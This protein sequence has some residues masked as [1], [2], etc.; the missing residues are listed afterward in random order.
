MEFRILGPLE[1]AQDGHLFT[2]RGR[3][4]QALL[5]LLLLNAGE[6]VSRERLIDE[7]W[8]DD[9]PPTAAKTLQVHV[10]RL[11][12]E[13]GDVVVTSGG[14]YLIEVEPGG[15]DLERFRQLVEE[16]REALAAGAPER[17]RERLRAALALW[18]GPPLAELGDHEFARVEAARL[19]DLRLD[20]VEERVEAE[21]A[22]G[23]RGE[24]IG[25]LEA[26]V[27]HHPYRERARALLMLTLYREGRRAEALEAYQDA[28]RALVDDLGIEPGPRLRELHAAILA[29][30]PARRA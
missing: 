3:K 2:V 19:A 12:R 23:H 15:L 27:A 30:D 14:G 13:L 8:A 16:G 22:L 24:A 6:V 17:A 7:L 18:R 28:R 5:T 4:L 11:R 10:S 1:V 21:L 20:A 9:P 26:V 25:A 29:Q